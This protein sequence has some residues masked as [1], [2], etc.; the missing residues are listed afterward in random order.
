VSSYTIASRHGHAIKVSKASYQPATD[1]V[2]IRPG[3]RFNAHR[4]YVLTIAG[5]GPFGLQSTSGTPLDGLSNGKPGSNFV[6]RV[7]AATRHAFRPRSV[8]S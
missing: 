6:A 2:T 7:P 5:T 8:S 1:S 4:N 3:R